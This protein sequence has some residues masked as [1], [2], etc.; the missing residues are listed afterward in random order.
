MREPTD[1]RLVAQPD[2]LTTRGAPPTGG[3]GALTDR[4][5]EETYFQ[6]PATRGRRLRRK[7]TAEAT[8]RADELRLR[9]VP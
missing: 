1:F 4:I 3:A 6:A 8:W 7:S 5:L 9:F 2:L